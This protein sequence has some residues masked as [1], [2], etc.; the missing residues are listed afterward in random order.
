MFILLPP[1]VTKI[2]NDSTQNG[3]RDSIYHLIE[4]L[5]TEA[6][7]TE[8]RDL[9]TSD[10]LPQPVEII[11]PR[12]EVEKEL[13]IT[14]LL[15]AIGAGELVIPDVAN[16]KGF[17]EDGEESVHLGAA[18]HRARIEVTEEGTTAAAA[19]AL[20]TFRSG[21]PLVP[22]VFNANHPFV[23]F[24]YEKAKRTIL[25]AGIFRNPNTPKNTAEAAWGNLWSLFVVLLSLK[26][27]VCREWVLTKCVTNLK[28]FFSFYDKHD[29]SIFAKDWSRTILYKNLCKDL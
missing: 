22:T 6:G 25:F 24:I 9:L 1:F 23:Y 29:R 26:Q 19:T 15:D 7:Y 3:E 4:R 20:Y 13:Q 17:V 2:S 27:N 16:L 5:S 28:I 18:V 14:T 12:F 21:R 11:L 8:I 10:S